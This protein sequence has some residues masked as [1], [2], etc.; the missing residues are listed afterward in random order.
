MHLRPK[1]CGE[2][3]R[4]AAK[5][6]TGGETLNAASQ[7]LHCSSVGSMNLLLDLCNGLSRVEA[8]GANLQR[9]PCISRQLDIKQL[10][11]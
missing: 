8:L 6:N 4:K 1:N 10:Q 11:W 2:N 5:A 9:E 3:R 7:P